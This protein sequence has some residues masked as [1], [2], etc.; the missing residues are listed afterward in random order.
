MQSNCCRSCE[1][2]CLSNISKKR[3][4]ERI[5]ILGNLLCKELL[6]ASLTS[7]LVGNSFP[8]SLLSSLDTKHFPPSLFVVTLIL[9]AVYFRLDVLPF[10]VSSLCSLLEIILRAFGTVTGQLT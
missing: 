5:A 1:L 10:L 9:I 2:R 7:R 8:P 4:P 3:E 6:S